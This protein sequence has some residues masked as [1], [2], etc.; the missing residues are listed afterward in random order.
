MLVLSL[1]KKHHI[2]AFGFSFQTP[3]DWHNLEAH[4][5]MIAGTQGVGK[6]FKLDVNRN[7]ALVNKSSEFLSDDY[8]VPGSWWQMQYKGLVQRD[9]G[10]WYMPDREEGNRPEPE[11]LND[12]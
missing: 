2:Y 12:L 1:T 10:F 9:D 5:H 8:L 11:P 6:P 7:V 3:G 4:L